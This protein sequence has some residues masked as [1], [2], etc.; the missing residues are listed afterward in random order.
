M[1]NTSDIITFPTSK[2]GWKAD[3]KKHKLGDASIHHTPCAS[4]SKISEAQYLLLRSFW[5]TAKQDTKRNAKDWGITA[6]S[7]ARRWLDNED[8]WRKYLQTLTSTATTPVPRLGSFSYVHLSRHQV[9]RLPE[10]FREEEGDKNVS[11]SPIAGRLR[12][13]KYPPDGRI[14][15]DS[16]LAKKGG[17]YPPLSQSSDDDYDNNSFKGKAKGKD[18][19]QGSLTEAFNKFGLE[20]GS[21]HGSVKS[22]SSESQM[23]SSFEMS[24]NSYRKAFPKV[25]D[26]QIVNGFLI[27]FLATLCMHNP[28]VKLEWSPVRKALKFGKVEAPASGEKAFLFEARTDGHLSRPGV[29]DSDVRSAMIVEVKPT[30]RGYNN[31]VIHQA[32]AQMAAWIYAEADDPSTQQPYRRA[33]I[34][35]ERHEIRLVIATYDQA[36]V[37]YLHDKVDAASDRSLL[38]MHEYRVWDIQKEAQMRDFGV[39]LLAL[40]L[41][42]GKL[43]Y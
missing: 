1:S 15:P 32:T 5:V 33:M 16:P 29:G 13:T 25:E 37:D 8:D 11:F 41:Q 34:L 43:L 19:A 20:E 26:E 3:A 22:S 18:K 28:D 6:T 31:R 21:V 10:T 27:A 35:Q 17:H 36:Y 30:L 23:V 14:T 12:S 40:A 38:E 4:A 7:E 9:T 2:D 42:N 39:T 24:P